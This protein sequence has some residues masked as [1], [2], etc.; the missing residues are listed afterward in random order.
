MTLLDHGPHTVTVYPQE[1]Y[2]DSYGNQTHRPAETGVVVTGC[3]VTPVTS[4][5]D[6]LSD[7][8]L[9]GGIRLLARYA[10]LGPWARVEWDGRSYAVE[11]VHRHTASAATSHTVATLAPE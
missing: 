8:R 3:T 10:P 2:T 5:R 1:P 9:L 11:V 6:P 4:S 7:R